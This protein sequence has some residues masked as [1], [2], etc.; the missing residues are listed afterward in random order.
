MQSQRRWFYYPALVLHGHV[1]SGENTTALFP[2]FHLSKSL[3][4]ECKQKCWMCTNCIVSR[5]ETK[6]N[7]CLWKNISYTIKLRI[8]CPQFQ[9]GVYPDSMMFHLQACQC[10]IDFIKTLTL[11]S[12]PSKVVD[13][14]TNPRIPYSA[15]VPQP[16]WANQLPWNR[17]NVCFQLQPPHLQWFPKHPEI[18]PL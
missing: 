4:N 16:L 9:P 2:F 14:V 3:C 11:T 18:P 1:D 13:P 7:T 8:I 12:E 6:H 17:G 10:I 5:T 15:P